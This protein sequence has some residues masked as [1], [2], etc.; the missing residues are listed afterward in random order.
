[1][2]R[3]LLT[4]T[5]SQVKLNGKSTQTPFETGIGIPQKDGVSPILFTIYLETAL[6]NFSS[7]VTN[8][9]PTTIDTSKNDR[10]Y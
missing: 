9:R 1:M 10:V 4:N 2:I 6:R 3:K 8:H 5:C 7:K